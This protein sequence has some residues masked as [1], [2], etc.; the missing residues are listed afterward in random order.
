MNYWTRKARAE[1]LGGRKHVLLLGSPTQLSVWLE[2]RGYA[3][4]FGE[5][6]VLHILTIEANKMV[7]AGE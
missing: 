2:H 3:I 7:L 1:A 6:E 4:E 5:V